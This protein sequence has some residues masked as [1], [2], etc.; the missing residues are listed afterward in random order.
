MR[1]TP[2][3]MRAIPRDNGSLAS[4]RSVT[5]IVGVLAAKIAAQVY[6]RRFSHRK[7]QPGQR[8]SDSVASFWSDV[9]LEVLWRALM[10]TAR[11]RKEIRKMRFSTILD[12]WESGEIRQDAAAELLGMSVRSFQ[13]WKER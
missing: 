8:F 1:K 13:R 10:D 2:P 11:I 4:R 12:R 7:L 9:I 6:S 5:V 3:G